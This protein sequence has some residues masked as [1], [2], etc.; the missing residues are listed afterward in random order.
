MRKKQAATIVDIAKR[1]G[2][3]IATVSRALNDL[4]TVKSETKRKVL[5]VAKELNYSINFVAKSLVRRESYTIGCLFAGGG[6]IYYHLQ[7]VITNEL[8]KY[9]YSVIF[10]FCNDSLDLQQKY[11]K[12]LQMQQVDGFIVCPIAGTGQNAKT[13]LD[14]TKKPYVFFNRFINEASYNKVIIDFSKSH[15]EAMNHI[16]LRG[17]KRIYGISHKE[18]RYPGDRVSTMQALREKHG[19]DLE[20]V[21]INV[22]S[23][24]IRTGYFLAKAFFA[25]VK[26]SRNDTAFFCASDLYALGVLRACNDLNLKVP[27][28]ILIVGCYSQYDFSNFTTPRLSSFDCKFPQMVEESVKR[29][30]SL[31][32]DKP[33]EK[34][35]I[36]IESDFIPRETT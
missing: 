25:E 4:P 26:S 15:L 17:C 32:D 10:Y 30:I 6:G 34:E 19:L 27:E 18:A 13:A 24:D 12:L 20:V 21:P 36:W 1:L 5:S 3:S 33:F 35:V 31:I 22:K 9:G 2:Y 8:E 16:V 7:P 14:A 29:L 11:I 28:D 23:D